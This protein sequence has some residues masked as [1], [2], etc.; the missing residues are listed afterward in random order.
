MLRIFHRWIFCLLLLGA[1]VAFGK[2]GVGGLVKFAIQVQYGSRLAY[3]EMDW[4]GGRLIFTDPVLFDVLGKEKGYHLRAQRIEVAFSFDHFPSSLGIF[5]EVAS[6][7]ITLF[8]PPREIRLGASDWI[9][10]RLKMEEGFLEWP[11]MKLH[12]RVRAEKTSPR[13][14]GR[15]VLVSESSQVEMEA[16][17]DA[18]GLRLEAAL[19]HFDA[20]LIQPWIEWAGW[21]ICLEKGALDGWVHLE[22]AKGEWQK[23]SAHGEVKELAAVGSWGHAGVESASFD[24]DG[25]FDFVSNPLM[26]SVKVPGGRI[27]LEASKGLVR[28]E[29]GGVEEI[30]GSFTYTS[31][32]GVRWEG[33]GTGILG[34]ERFP[35][36]CQGRGFWPLHSA[37]WLEAE[38]EFPQGGFSLKGQTKEGVSLWT[39]EIDRLQPPYS[40]LLQILASVQAPIL[41]EIEWKSGSISCKVE[42]A[43]SEEKMERWKIESFEMN[44]IVVCRRG[45][46]DTHLGFG[47]FA[48]HIGSE[49]WK[50]GFSLE[51]GHARIGPLG[52]EIRAW[53]WNA[54]GSLADGQ[55][56]ASR[57]RGLL[58]EMSFEGAFSGGAEWQSEGSCQNFH[59]DLKGSWKEGMVILDL[60]QVVGDGFFWSGSGYVDLTSW[61][62]IPFSLTTQ[63]ISCDLSLISE[64]KGTLAS[65]HFFCRGNLLESFTSWEWEL[66][67]TLA[68]GSCT[69]PNGFRLEQGKGK[70][71]A[72]PRDWTIEEGSA[73]LVGKGRKLHLA[74][75]RLSK[76]GDDVSFDLRIQRGF[77]DL[78][79]FVG[80]EK[81]GVI[82]FDPKTEL[83]GHPLSIQ[84][85]S[86][87]NE[88]LKKFRCQSQLS[89]NSI[90]SLLPALEDGGLAFSWLAKAPLSGSADVRFSFAEGEM[91]ASLEGIDLLWKGKQLPFQFS[92]KR[93]DH[94]WIV[95]QAR[96]GD[97]SL[98]CRILNENEWWWVK[99]GKGTWLNGSTGLFEGKWDSNGK[100]QISFAGLQVDAAPFFSLFEI[101]EING[102]IKGQGWLAFDASKREYETDLDLS[103]VALSTG[104][105]HFESRGPVHVFFSP[106]KGLTLQGVDF[107]AE[108]EGFSP[109]DGKIGWVQFDLDH[110]TWTMNHAH[111]HLPGALAASFWSALDSDHDIDFTADLQIASDLSIFSCQMKEGFIPFGGSLR[112]L[113][114]LKLDW[115]QNRIA[116]EFCYFHQSRCIRSNLHIERGSSLK[117]RLTLEDL[118]R[119]LSEGERP[120]SIDW[121]YEHS[122]GTAIHSIEGTFGG[123]EASFHAES[124][125][126]ESKLI[127]SGK[128]HFGLLS[129]LLP[130]SV[131][132]VFT[133]LEM[134]KGYEL[135]GKLSI[136]CKDLSQIFFR[137]ILSGKQ[138]ELFG[139]QFRTLLAQADLGPDKMR[140]FDLKISDTAGML[141]IDEMSMG[142]QGGEP[143]TIS[144]PLISILDLRPSLLQ[145]PGEPPGEIS[146]L[147]VRD[148]KI[149][150]FQGI[151]EDGNTYTGYG[152]LYFINSYKREHTVFDL[153]SDVL[154]R[155][156]GLDM[157]L[158]I[159]V[160]GTLRYVLKNG[161]FRITEL[162]EAYSEGQR[163]EFFL[164][165]TDESPTVDLDGNIKIHVKMKQ[166][167]LFK[168][169]EAFVIT[170]D[171]KLNDPHYHMQ[172]KKRFL[173]L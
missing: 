103:S 53:D 115:N 168:L 91:A 21:D 62:R 162:E 31:E 127:G 54:S 52:R 157:E 116:S 89:W 112:H 128:I 135:K 55:V 158:L 154:G 94:Q 83:L 129:E 150:D 160:T 92:A 101:P 51:G 18:K 145:K 95:E 26:G 121:E 15:V 41:R 5:I 120:L 170:I 151:L 130:S 125:G 33:A 72:T 131:A 96:F 134:G 65:E 148:M 102:A 155:I 123:V 164:I 109:V 85:C 1:I 98:S 87:G 57:W 119:P 88:G 132:E 165:H 161:A 133:E 10:L 78:A 30:S 108:K 126:D 67:A 93:D 42:G 60:S 113:Q 13:Q 61:E 80:M 84:E 105:F 66:A 19:T 167:V 146:P 100:G 163:S 45:D 71:I 27:R 114:D 50:G 140:I 169:T 142:G 106:E 37:P 12:A 34:Q 36:S 43:F 153:P 16:L 69:L 86:Y 107:H 38:L 11:D 143:W 144:I 111:I 73:E 46:E 24:W 68:D 32:L 6:P 139:Y 4:E 56:A 166:F 35:I 79:R 22:S 75:T 39:A 149:R 23:G 63:R 20:R 141:K 47:T 74:A 58:N 28:G 49:G 172:K 117:G 7:H 3:R 81:G 2:S 138:L 48:A 40:H 44:Q 152:E 17:R 137:G 8:G 147:V 171:G 159:P 122:T 59:F 104:P 99:S 90:L 136:D 97:A 110:S 9:D 82:S 70:F 64:Q 25:S 14:I 118:E 76:E 29:K 77:W 156:I 124:I 173:G